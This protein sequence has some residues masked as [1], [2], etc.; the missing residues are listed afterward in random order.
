MNRKGNMN[1][2]FKRVIILTISFALTANSLFIGPLHAQG[3]DRAKTSMSAKNSISVQ[4]AKS[5]VRHE[6]YWNT[7]VEEDPAGGWKTRKNKITVKIRKN[8]IVVKGKPTLTSTRDSGADSAKIKQLGFKKRVYKISRKT[9]Y[10]VLHW[11][12]I[13]K[14]RKSLAIQSI[15]EKQYQGFQLMLKGKKGTKITKVFLINHGA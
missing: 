5:D 2:M 13:E 4:A 11:N 8:R 1:T 3:A 15:K 10:F 14:V 9:K 6:Y 7:I 12:S